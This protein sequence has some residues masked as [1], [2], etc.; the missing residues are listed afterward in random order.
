LSE[1]ARRI[2]KTL[3]LTEPIHDAGETITK[4]EFAKPKARLY[5]LI[6]SL[7]EIGGDQVLAVIADLTGISVEA[8]EEMDWDDAEAA[9][10]IVGDLLKPKKKAR[11]AG[12]RRRKG[13]GKN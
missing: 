9:A 3:D 8:I 6:D 13:G 7:T 1:G 2:V 4:L 12:G 5:R 11:P 10:E